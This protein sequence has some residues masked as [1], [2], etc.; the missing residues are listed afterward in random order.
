MDQ[1]D[2]QELADA[3]AADIGMRRDRGDVRLVGHHPDA[4]VADDTAQLFLQLR[5][6]RWLRRAQKAGQPADEVSSGLGVAGELWA[7][8]SAPARAHHPGG[9]RRCSAPS[10]FRAISRR[11]AFCGQGCGNESFSIALT[12]GICS[13]RIGSTTNAVATF[14]V[15]RVYRR[16]LRRLRPLGDVERVD[17]TRVAGV[18]GWAWRQPNSARNPARLAE[19]ALLASTTSTAVPVALERRA[20]IRR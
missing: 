10:G 15:A 12:A 5:C 16:P 8:A 14:T 1:R 11:Y 19:A 2:Q 18:A 6:A 3:L 7:A 4:G 20:P 13:T 9:A 17:C